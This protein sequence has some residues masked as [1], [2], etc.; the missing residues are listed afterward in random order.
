MSVSLKDY[1]EFMVSL[2]IS[3]KERVIAVNII[4]LKHA[5]I[6]IHTTMK[7]TDSSLI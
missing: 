7:P 3:H 2:E 5:T 4:D 1:N 6:E